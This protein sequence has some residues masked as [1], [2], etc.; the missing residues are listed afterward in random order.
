MKGFKPRCVHTM[1]PY[2]VIAG[3]PRCGSC[4]ADWVRENPAL[5]T[6]KPGD[7]GA[8][9]GTN[10]ERADE[11]LMAGSPTLTAVAW[12]GREFPIPEEEE[13]KEA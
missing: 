7:A 12:G 5:F 9:P 2:Q 8:V 6:M 11:Q 10:V 3:V 4:G 13:K 1:A